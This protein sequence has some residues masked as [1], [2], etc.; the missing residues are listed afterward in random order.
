MITSFPMVGWRFPAKGRALVD[1]HIV[2]DD[3]GFADHNKA[4]VDEQV[5]S[6]LRTRM[7]VDRGQE[8]AE[9]VHHPRQQEQV[10]PV[11]RMGDPVHPDCP[12]TGVDQDFPTRARRRIAGPDAR[13]IIGQ[14]RK[15]GRALVLLHPPHSGW[16]SFH[17][18]A[19]AD[20][21]QTGGFRRVSQAP[22]I[23]LNISSEAIR[24]L[25]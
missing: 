13:E 6:D 10:H 22:R 4:M 20:N 18:A 15:H 9:M 19:G 11:E 16:R 2:P 7:D 24:M 23:A 17:I 3:R 1:R 21:F 12:D 25:R 8:T 5:F 14:A